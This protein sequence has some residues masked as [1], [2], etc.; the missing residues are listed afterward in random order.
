MNINVRD[1]IGE[2]SLKDEDYAK[3][4]VRE[5]AKVLLPEAGAPAATRP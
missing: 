1:G 4:V 5:L 3:V 2:F